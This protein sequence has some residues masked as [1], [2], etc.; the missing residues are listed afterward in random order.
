M[1]RPS[2]SVV[3][4]LD[5]NPLGDM[6]TQTRA[7]GKTVLEQADKVRGAVHELDWKGETANATIDRGNRD[8]A[9]VRKAIED[10]FN[11]LA[12]A[13]ADGKNAMGPMIDT[14]KSDGRGF[15]A[16]SF[17]VSEDW[18]VTDK[19]PYDL[20]RTLAG[21]NQS[22]LDELAKVQAQRA[23]E[24][25]TG[26]A[27]LQKLADELGVADEN[28]NKAIT[29]AQSALYAL[30]P[31]RTGQELQKLLSGDPAP[32][33]AGVGGMTD[34]LGRLPQTQDQPGVPLKDKLGK[35]EIPIPEQ[36]LLKKD[37]EY[38]TQAGK[39]V[40]KSPEGKNT[41]PT[42]TTVGGRFGDQT[43]IGE[44]KGPTVWKGDAG[45]HGDQVNHWERKG[46]FSGI[47]TKWDV[48]S[49]Q[50]GWEAGA[51]AEVKK[52]SI[53]TKEHAGAYI[54]DNKGNL[55]VDLGDNG[56]VHGQIGGRLG[57]E[58]YGGANVVGKDGVKLGGGAFGGINTHQQLDYD[59]HG[60]QVQGRVD[61]YA[62]AGAGAHLTFAETP[63][64]KWKIGGSW[65]VAWGLGAKPSFEITVDPKEFGGEL[66]KLWQWVNN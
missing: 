4:K 5:V 50:L 26:T 35:P 2:K 43:K 13:Y 9:Q 21:G 48:Q 60:L 38:G 49:D 65:G 63:D 27:K 55:N 3:Y 29:E 59:G 22:I 41:T 10:G 51:K 37:K 39:G 64:H 19:F 61:E 17:D 54:I 33:P 36:E 30:T 58:E 66:G 28:T 56:K 14:L 16:D 31:S 44:G 45:E 18:K 25:D 32:T 20:A 47:H 62:G 7:V 52:D 15:E 8:Y 6:D 46:E 42:G 24:A 12:Q 34:V 40:D 53:E 23:N 11:K 57:V 1:G